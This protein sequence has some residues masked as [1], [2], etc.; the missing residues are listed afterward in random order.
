LKNDVILEGIVVWEPW[1]YMEDL[2][3]RV[4]V[5]R[6]SDIPARKLDNQRDA[7]DY[8]NIRE[9]GVSIILLCEP[10]CISRL[11]VWFLMNCRLSSLRNISY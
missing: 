5:N 9:N 10:I 4:T 1:K 11:L 2:F 3:F 6:D 8:V 7:S